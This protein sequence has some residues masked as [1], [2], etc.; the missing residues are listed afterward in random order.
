MR[1]SNVQEVA[2]HAARDHESALALSL[3]AAWTDGIGPSCCIDFTKYAQK[4]ISMEKGYCLIQTVH[5]SRLLGAPVLGMRARRKKRD[6]TCSV[7]HCWC[8]KVTTIALQTLVRLPTQPAEMH[9]LLHGP[10]SSAQSGKP[11]RRDLKNKKKTNK[12]RSAPSSLSSRREPTN[13]RRAPH[14]QRPAN[15]VAAAGKRT[16]L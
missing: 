15:V 7:C 6:C 2:S 1:P 9:S 10:P 3:A 8:K 13:H 4:M 12:H 16:E 14:G 5:R 11:P